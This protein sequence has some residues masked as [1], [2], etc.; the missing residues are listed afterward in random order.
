MLYIIDNKKDLSGAR[1]CAILY[2]PN[3]CKDPNMQKWSIELPLKDSNEIQKRSVV[4]GKLITVMHLTDIHY[5]PLYLPGSNAD[6][7]EKEIC[8]EREST[9]KPNGS[10]VPAGYWGDYHTCDIPWHSVQNAFD[11]IKARNVRKHCKILLA[12]IT[13]VFCFSLV[14]N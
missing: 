8:C 4:D 5:D 9:L 11:D 14:V 10:Y 12:V 2:Q 7:Y 3:N 6:C 13:P 1:V